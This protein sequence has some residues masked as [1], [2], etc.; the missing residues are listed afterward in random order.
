MVDENRKVPVASLSFH[1]IVFVL[2]QLLLEESISS[3]AI[4]QQVSDFV[5]LIWAEA[6]GHLD[7]LLFESLNNISLND[8]S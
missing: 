4:S 7:S 6:V 1:W 2:L 3:S 5:E 8:V